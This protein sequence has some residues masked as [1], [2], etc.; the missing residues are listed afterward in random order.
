MGVAGI[1]VKPRVV[2]PRKKLTVS[3]KESLVEQMDRYMEY[4]GGAT[5]RAY[6]MEQVLE[7]FPAHDRDFQRWPLGRR[8]G[9]A[10][11]VSGLHRAGRLV[12]VWGSVGACRD[13]TGFPNGIGRDLT[14]FPDGRFGLK[15]ASDAD[16][17][18]I[19]RRRIALTAT[20][21]RHR[22]PGGIREGWDLRLRRRAAALLGR[23]R[24]APV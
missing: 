6:G 1:R 8:G 21:V 17:P 24:T 10:A 12:D 13:L 7:Q 11:G 14:G 9:R 5:D 15:P 3:L 4:L 22:H 2:E 18:P 20:R 19:P 16:I 23:A